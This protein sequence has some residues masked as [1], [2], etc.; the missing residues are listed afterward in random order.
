MPELDPATQQHLARVAQL[1]SEGPLDAAE[2]H[3]LQQLLERSPA[4]REEFARAM[5]F[6][7]ML[8]SEFPA[9]VEVRIPGPIAPVFSSRRWFLLGSAGVA[10]ISAILAAVWIGQPPHQ[11][12]PLSAEHSPTALRSQVATIT[13][14]TLQQPGLSAGDRLLLG[15]WQFP[16]G[17]WELLFDCGTCMTVTGPAELTSESD[18]RLFLAYGG[19]AVD[20]PKHADGFVVYTPSG[21]I[22]DLGTSFGLQVNRD[23]GT[24]LHVLEGEV[25]AT[26]S[27]LLNAD[28]RVVREQEAFFFAADSVRRVPFSAAPFRRPRP[29]PP[30]RESVVHWTFD[31]RHVAITSDVSGTYSLELHRRDRGEDRPEPIQSVPGVFGACLT[32][33]GQG[34]FAITDYAGVTGSRARTTAFWVRAPLE[35]DDARNAGCLVSWGRG[36]PRQK[37]EIALNRF[38]FQGQL[39]ALRV[40]LGSGFVIGSTDLSDGDWHHVAAVF[41]GGHDADLTTHVKLYVDG[42]LESITGRM[43]QHV[44]TAGDDGQATPVTLGRFIDSRANKRQ[45]YFRG[46]F[47]ELVIVEGALTPAEIVALLESNHPPARHPRPIEP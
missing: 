9:D 6:E 31:E 17:E 20:V 15:T 24:A 10:V 4:A 47:D 18:F 27:S 7:A 8:M 43:S 23:G 29:I 22:R 30:V 3:Q 37:W 41:Y 33:H 2:L 35:V 40:D 13:R 42:R 19:V 36:E 46:Q 25:E 28:P 44:S 45:K 34:E 5:A 12:P 1:V 32:L 16:A 21:H 11:K 38:D 39:G 14:A 26:S